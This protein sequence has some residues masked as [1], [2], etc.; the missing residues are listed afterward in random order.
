MEEFLNELLPKLVGK[1]I[2]KKDVN[3]W[4]SKN[5]DDHETGRVVRKTAPIELRTNLSE[6]EKGKA[7]ENVATSLGLQYRELHVHFLYV[8]QNFGTH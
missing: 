1:G 2:Q 6:V 7:L 4:F 8:L 5:L 3:E